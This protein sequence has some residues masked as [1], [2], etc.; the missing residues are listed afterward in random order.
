MAIREIFDHGINWLGKQPQALWEIDISGI[1][2][3]VERYGNSCYFKGIKIKKGENE[4]YELSRSGDE[5]SE[6]FFGKPFRRYNGDQNCFVEFLAGVMVKE[7]SEDVK[8]ELDENTEKQ[9]Q[10]FLQNIIKA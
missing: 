6:I 4:V 5:R 3:R 7:T 1:A 2:L 9:Y 8:V 10:L